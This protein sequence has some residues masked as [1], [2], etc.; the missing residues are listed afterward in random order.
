MLPLTKLLTADPTVTVR[1][2]MNG[3]E[4]AVHVDMPD[5]EVARLFSER[6]LISAPVINDDGCLV[7]RITIDDV[8]DVII[9]DAEEA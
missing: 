6:D 8:V 7:G 9:E 4:P 3:D 1:E 5:T 2:I